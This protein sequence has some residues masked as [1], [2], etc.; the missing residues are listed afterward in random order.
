MGLTQTITIDLQWKSNL[1]IRKLPAHICNQNYFLIYCTKLSLIFINLHIFTNFYIFR[2]C[3]YT[4]NSWIAN[5]IV[6][7]LKT[8]VHTLY[9]MAG[10]CKAYM[11]VFVYSCHVYYNKIR[12]Y[13]LY[14]IYPVYIT[15]TNNYQTVSRRET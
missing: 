7:I 14:K 4:L 15:I 6:Y 5:T 12:A 11:R 2:H 1:Q 3:M 10:F 8:F 9:T 13:A